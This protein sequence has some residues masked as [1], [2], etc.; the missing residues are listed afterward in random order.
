MGRSTVRVELHNHQSGGYDVLHA[1]MEARG[2]ERMIAGD[3]G[4]AFHLP[5]A[6]CNYEGSIRGSE[7]DPR[8]GES[9]RH[10][11]RPRL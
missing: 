5:T 1:E 3:D 2:F 7:G 9:G 8:E 10:Q 4:R 6:E 11:R